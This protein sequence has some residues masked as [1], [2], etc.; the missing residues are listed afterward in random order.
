MLTARSTTASKPSN[1]LSE[2]TRTLWHT[3]E[4]LLDKSKISR[5]FSPR[6]VTD[7][8]QFQIDRPNPLPCFSPPR[9]PRYDRRIHNPGQGEWPSIYR[10]CIRDSHQTI[11]AVSAVRLRFPGQ[12]GRFCCPHHPYQLQR[13]PEDCADCRCHRSWIGGSATDPRAHRC[14]SRL[15][16]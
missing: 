5:I 15:R 6:A 11:Q 2:T 7:I 13:G 12:E 8:Y 3:S 1:S 4:T 9:G 10:H 14:S 16:C